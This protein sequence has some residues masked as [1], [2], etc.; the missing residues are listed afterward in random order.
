M[1]SDEWQGSHRHKCRLFVQQHCCGRAVPAALHAAI[2]SL[3]S[4]CPSAWLQLSPGALQA[5]RTQLLFQHGLSSRLLSCWGCRCAHQQQRC[6][7]DAGTKSTN[8]KWEEQSKALPA[9]ACD[10]IISTPLSKKRF[11]GLTQNIFNQI[12]DFYNMQKLQLSLHISP[13]LASF[14]RLSWERQ[15]SITE[16]CSMVMVLC[17]PSATHLCLTS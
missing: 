16:Q 13:Q 14:D 1:V 4:S 6:F 9:S 12:L 2:Q 15:T 8:Q 17:R 5:G 10:K 3:C 11:L 7:P